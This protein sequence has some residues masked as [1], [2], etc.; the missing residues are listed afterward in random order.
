MGTMIDLRVG[1]LVADWGKNEFFRDHRSLFQKTDVRNVVQGEDAVGQEGWIKT[2]S[3]PLRDVLPRLR[4]LGY[5]LESARREYSALLEAHADEDNTWPSFD[6]LM[7]ALWAT[8]VGDVSADYEDDHSFGEFF[9]EEIGPRINVD[10][11]FGSLHA[12]QWAFAEMM[13][14]FHP[15]NVLVLLAEKSENLGLPVVW[16]YF[17]HLANGWSEEADF[18]PKL[19]AEERF[20][21]VTEGSSDSKVIQKALAI[22]KPSIVDFFTFIDMEDGY[23]FSG[24]G[25]LASFCRGL[26]KISIQNK[27]LVLF[28][29]DAEGVSKHEA[30]A[31]LSAPSSMRILRLPDHPGLSSIRCIGTSGEM[32]NDI[33]GRAASIEAYLDLEWHA[34]RPAFVRWTNYVQSLETYQGALDSKEFYVRQFLDL[35][36]TCAGYD[37]TKLEA[38]LSTLIQNAEAVAKDQPA[39]AEY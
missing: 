17:E 12:G 3:R 21:I 1:N 22:L 14:N 23:P 38:I 33:N 9:R 36:P 35:R 19:K 15:W 29:N 24:S 4:L 13:E 8:D 26:A 31:N 11:L 18:L 37:T 34:N 25:N 20:L 10:A 6:A 28:D 7:V 5:T 27:T 30:L 39:R 32:H 16:D 2:L